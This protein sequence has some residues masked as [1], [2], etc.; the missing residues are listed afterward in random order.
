MGE[1]I[2][3]LQEAA[4]DV[5]GR[6]EKSLSPTAQKSKNENAVR[7]MRNN[8]WIYCSARLTKLRF[9]HEFTCDFVE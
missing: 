9:A 6:G 1:I 3:R 8:S 5:S 7:N 2:R 4:I